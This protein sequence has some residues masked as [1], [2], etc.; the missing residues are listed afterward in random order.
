MRP[1]ASSSNTVA[2]VRRTPPTRANLRVTRAALFDAE[3]GP[4][5]ERFRAIAAI[6]PG[7]RVLDIGCGTGESTRQAAQAAV[8]GTV[9][10]VDVWDEVLDV[11]RRLS[12]GLT[13]VSYRVGDAQTFAFSRGEFDVAISRFGTMFF[14][15]P[16]A[17]FT[18][19]ATALRTG[20]RLAL[21]V[22][23]TRERNS[24]SVAVRDRIGAGPAPVDAPDA[25]SLGD[26]AVVERVLGA[27]GYA[28]V[29]FVDVDETIYSGPDVDTAYEFVTGLR[30][31]QGWIARLDPAAADVARGRLRDLLA[32]HATDDGVFFD[33]RAWVVTAVRH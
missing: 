8:D 2:S 22:W 12:A 15:D 10:G 5:N 24:W 29:A 9:L 32:E 14:A 30:D 7:E 31:T 26:P 13:N 23:Q 17:A 1:S 3:I 33:S 25:F 18:N 16:I 28:D 19:I 4:H 6:K 20:A 11:A 27:A 21:L